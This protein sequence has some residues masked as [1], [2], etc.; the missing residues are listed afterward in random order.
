MCAGLYA[1]KG[2]P[3]VTNGGSLAEREPDVAAQWHPSLN[4]DLRPEHFA[5]KSHRRVW[6][7]CDEG[8]EWETTITH[9]VQNRSGCMKCVAK[10]RVQG[11]VGKPVT[12]HPALVTNADLMKEWNEARNR[13]I[14]PAELTYGSNQRVWWRCERGH[15]WETAVGTRGIYGA[16]C[17]T[18][19]GT[20]NGTLAEVR[21]DLA[22]LWHSDLNGDLTPGM[23]SPASNRRVWWKCRAGHET[24]NVIKAKVAA[25]NECVTC[26]NPRRGALPEEAPEAA[27]RWHPVRNGSL[28]PWDVTAGSGAFVWWLCESGHQ[29]IMQVSSQ[30]RAKGNGCPTCRRLQHGTFAQKHPRLAAMWHPSLNGDTGPDDVPAATRQKVWW[31]CPAGH[32]THRS[33]LHVARMGGCI[34]CPKKD[35]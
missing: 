11:R 26:S 32:E 9:R 30:A 20:S 8:H 16:G 35:R 25:L 15:E 5:H 22:L 18:C 28:S 23:V 24:Q 34:T 27:K 2:L 29:W 17:P 14:D 33:V 10:A 1:P 4:G 6:W 7:I 19:K 21:P 13:G 3:K 12:R 31:L